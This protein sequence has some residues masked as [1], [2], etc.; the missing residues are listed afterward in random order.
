MHLY[1]LQKNSPLFIVYLRSRVRRKRLLHDDA[2]AVLDGGARAQVH[3]LT[4]GAV[5]A[6]HARPRARVVVEVFQ[7]GARDQAARTAAHEH[8]AAGTPWCDL[9]NIFC[10]CRRIFSFVLILVFVF[11]QKLQVCF[12]S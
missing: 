8:F 10:Y 5:A 4:E 6:L 7:R 11:L 12:A 3:D 9:F 2:G 1:S